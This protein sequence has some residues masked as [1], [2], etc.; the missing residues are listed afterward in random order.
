MVSY[1]D[2]GGGRW[3]LGGGRW[4]EEEEA[5]EEAEPSHGGEGKYEESLMHSSIPL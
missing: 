2:M 1:Q 5:Q 3:E 4:E